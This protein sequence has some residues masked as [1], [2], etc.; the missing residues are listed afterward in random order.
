MGERVPDLV[1]DGSEN[2]A[3]G[4]SIYQNLQVMDGLQSCELTSKHTVFTKWSNRMAR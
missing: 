3:G 4:E 2:E 1:I